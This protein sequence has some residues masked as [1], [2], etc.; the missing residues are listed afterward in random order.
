MTLYD[1]K[2]GEKAQILSI[3]ENI[4]IKSRLEKLGFFAGVDVF[5]VRKGVFNGPIQIKLRNFSLALRKDIAE[6]I[7]VKI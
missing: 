2:N 5:V 3:G 4:K 1:V 7:I 6:K